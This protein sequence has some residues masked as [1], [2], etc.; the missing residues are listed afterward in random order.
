[1]KKLILGVVLA[2]CVPA[3]RAALTPAQLTSAEK[4]TYDGLQN[5][6]DAA[7]RYLA[8]REYLREC[9][10]VVDGSLSAGKLEFEPD[11]FDSTYVSS[12][13]Q[14]IVDRA[15]NMNIAAMLSRSRSA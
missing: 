4:Q 7:Q 6:R 10:K 14:K 3:A 1:M 13:E 9:R 8:T 5:D 15:I 2:L 12:A 11:E